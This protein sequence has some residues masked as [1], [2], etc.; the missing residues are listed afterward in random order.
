MHIVLV[1]RAEV[2]EME[3]TIPALSEPSRQLGNGKINCLEFSA[4]VWPANVARTSLIIV[5]TKA[6]RMIAPTGR[7]AGG[8]KAVDI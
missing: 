7:L 5:E 4:V 2:A 3:P 8:L 6:V 1:R